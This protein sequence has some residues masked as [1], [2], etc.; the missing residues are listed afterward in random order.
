MSSPLSPPITTSVMRNRNGGTSIIRVEEKT[1]DIEDLIKEFSQQP[2]NRFCA[3]CLAKG[4]LYFS[5]N[6]SCM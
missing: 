3:D 5:M 1:K 4:N 6:V 2:G